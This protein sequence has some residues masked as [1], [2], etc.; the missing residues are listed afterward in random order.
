MNMVLH[1]CLCIVIVFI[2]SKHLH[3]FSIIKISLTV[4]KRA[5]QKPINL[6]KPSQRSTLRRGGV[7][8]DSGTHTSPWLILSPVSLSHFLISSHLTIPESDSSKDENASSSSASASNSNRCSLIMVKNIA[9]LIP[10]SRGSSVEVCCE[11]R[12]PGRDVSSSSIISG[13]GTIPKVGWG[14]HTMF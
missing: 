11:P 13:D 12:S 7:H 10:R 5:F 9:K 6:C 1:L 2:Y 8:D 3:P 14:E 4:G